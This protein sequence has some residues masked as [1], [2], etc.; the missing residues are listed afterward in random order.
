[1]PPIYVYTD[2][3]NFKDK[4]FNGTLAKE[5]AAAVEQK[6]QEMVVKV[7]GKSPGFTTGKVQNP[8]GYAIRLKIA[9]LESTPHETKCTL[10]GEL[11]RYPNAY[12]VK[13][14][15]QAMVSTSFNGSAAATG[16]GKFAVIDCVEAIAESMVAKAIPAMRSD[17]TR[18]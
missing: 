16:M 3:S 17:I 18:W 6:M 9:K 4:T 12:S 14:S 1:M 10:S 2:N 11:I 13:G 8:K 7:I 5:N 15:G